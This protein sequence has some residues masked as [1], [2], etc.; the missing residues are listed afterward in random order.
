MAT[1]RPI[2]RPAD[3][4]DGGSGE[5]SG[6]T[7]SASSTTERRRDVPDEARGVA[8]Q[9][10]F[11]WFA[12]AGIATRGVVYGL[13]GFLALELALGVGG[14]TTSQS[15]ALATIAHQPLGE[16][17]LIVVAI[18]LAAYAIWRLFTAAFGS[19]ETQEHETARRLAALASGIAYGGLCY[20]AVRIL[21]G[22]GSSGGSSSP[23]SETAGVLGWPGGTAI[24]A[25]SGAAVI[26]VGLIQA[27]RGL[28]QDFLEECETA[29]MSASAQRSFAVLGVFGHLARAVVFGLVGYGLITAALNYSPRSA[30]GLDG[31]LQKLS[32]STDGPLLLGIV[33]AGLLG[34]GLY[35]IVDARY[36]KV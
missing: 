15:G 17:L 32:H 35:S 27:Y 2:A 30:I 5:A 7:V 4:F 11:E 29:R 14:K 16:V 23:K 36:H 21:V 22:S 12:R 19:R 20:T 24:V 1:A 6:H 18:G 33:A 25:V 3:Q 9:P 13:V 10:G 28:S 8:R 31:A 26:V 34:F